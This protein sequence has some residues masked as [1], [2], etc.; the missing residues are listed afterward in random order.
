MM[1]LLYAQQIPDSKTKNDY[2]STVESVLF[3]ELLDQLQET[4]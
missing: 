4:L 1:R 2:S 3:G